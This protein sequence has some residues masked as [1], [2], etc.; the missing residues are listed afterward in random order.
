MQLLNFD[1]I[2]FQFPTVNSVAHKYILFTS[3]G[4]ISNPTQTTAFYTT[5]SNIYYGGIQLIFGINFT[6]LLNSIN[7]KSGSAVSAQYYISEL[8]LLIYQC[9]TLYPYTDI[10]Q[11]QCFDGCGAGYYSNTQQV[12]L[13][14]SPSCITCSGSASHCTSC[15]SPYVVLYGYVCGCPKNTFQVT[16][17]NGSISCSP[18]GSFMTYCSVCVSSTVCSACLS[19]LVLITKVSPNKCV[20]NSGNV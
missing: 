7:I 15:P 2:N 10:N 18:C 19:N 4:I 13:P 17:A 6:S 20:C 11:T 12:C 9:P 3:N 16:A 5:Y 8:L 14:C 1:P